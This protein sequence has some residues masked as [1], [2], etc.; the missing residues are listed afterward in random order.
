MADFE[1]FYPK[2]QQAE[3]LFADNPADSGGMT[4][5]GIASQANPN[6]PGWHTILAALKALNLS[7]PVPR[8]DW[9][10]VNAYLKTNKALAASVKAFY[11]ANYWDALQLDYVNS[12]AIANELCDTGVNAGVSRS[13][14]YLQR[15]INV[16]NNLGRWGKDIVVDG[17]VGPNTIN[18]LNSHKRPDLVLKA[19]NILQGNLYITIAESSKSQEQFINSWFSR[20]ALA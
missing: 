17:K 12:Q 10:R 16:T 14:T 18:A 19:L 2:L 1:I 3:G 13:A 9:A 8:A 4:Y 7:R 15:A 20:V 6:W 5:A 11:K